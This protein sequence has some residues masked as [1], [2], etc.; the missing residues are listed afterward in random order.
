MG[1]AESST[2]ESSS[3]IYWRN[4]LQAYNTYV[5]LG[6][7]L[8]R[9]LKFDGVPGGNHNE[10]NWSKL[11]PS[12]FAFALDPWREVQPLAQQT[13]PPRLDLLSVNSTGTRAALR[14]T[15]RFGVQNYLEGASD[16][17][18]PWSSD[19]LSPTTEFWSTQ[20]LDVPLPATSKYFWRLRS[21]SWQ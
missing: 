21:T 16:L 11:L 4:A 19:S 5:R 6:H 8:G 9:E 10:T 13:Y 15:P 12:F 1:T 2:G 14:F 7:P 17:S 18:Q 3:D 20:D